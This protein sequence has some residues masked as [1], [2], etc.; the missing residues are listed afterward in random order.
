MQIGRCNSIST[1]FSSIL[2]SLHGRTVLESY[3]CHCH[4]AFCWLHVAFKHA[5]SQNTKDVGL[6]RT[7]LWSHFICPLTFLI[8][9]LTKTAGSGMRYLKS[10]IFIF[11]SSSVQF[12][13]VDFFFPLISLKNPFLCQL[14]WCLVCLHNSQCTQPKRLLDQWRIRRQRRSVFG[15]EKMPLN[16][17]LSL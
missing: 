17:S 9:G 14:F 2:F 7:T 10:I 15:P 12:L 4:R 1:D 16:K 5:T 8:T 11:I 3:F 6:N 13:N